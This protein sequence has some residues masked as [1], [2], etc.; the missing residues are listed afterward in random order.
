MGYAGRMECTCR[1]EYSRADGMYMQDVH[2]GWNVHAGMKYASRK[3][4]IC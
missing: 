3:V 2:A 1:M 4:T